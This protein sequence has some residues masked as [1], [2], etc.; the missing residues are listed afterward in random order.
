MRAQIGLVLGI[1]V[2]TAA[3][4][5]VARSVEASVMD[6]PAPRGA[7]GAAIGRLEAAWNQAR[8]AG[9]VVASA[10]ASIGAMLHHQPTRDSVALA[11][12]ESVQRV[13]VSLATARKL[14]SEGKRSECISAIEKI[15]SPVGLR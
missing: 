13:E 3:C 8:A 5:G 12:S 10:P 14:R 2:A 11:Q 6:D 1:A 15:T 9:R 7:C 4:T